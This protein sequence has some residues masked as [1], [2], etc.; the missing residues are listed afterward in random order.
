MFSAPA[1]VGAG[2]LLRAV[3]GPDGRGAPT[4][5]RVPNAAGRRSPATQLEVEPV[6]VLQDVCD[7]VRVVIVR[8]HRTERDVNRAVDH[9]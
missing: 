8:V 9:G 4:G 3:S 1:L 2:Y 6:E 5:R 7:R